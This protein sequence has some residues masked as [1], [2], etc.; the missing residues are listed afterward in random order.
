VD[1]EIDIED[2]ITDVMKRVAETSARLKKVRDA[3]REDT[4]S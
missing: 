4:V 2:R 3:E 1:R